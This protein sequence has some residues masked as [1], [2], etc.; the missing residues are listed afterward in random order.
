MSGKDAGRFFDL[1]RAVAKEK[2]GIHLAEH[3]NALIENRLIRLKSKVGF[4]GGLE[5]LM[6]AIQSGEYE[7][8]FISAFTTNQTSFFRE[9]TQLEHFKNEFLPS[10][11]KTKNS[12]SV[13]SAGCSSGEEP[14]SM[15]MC[16]LSS[17]YEE[18]A[19]KITAMDIDEEKLKSAKDGIYSQPHTNPFPSY[20]SQN[21]YFSA[22]DE[23]GVKKIKIKDDVK[24]MVV[25]EK[26]NLANNKEIL[27][28]S[29]YDAV[30]CRN[31][32]IYFDK[33]KQDEILKKLLQ[34]LKLGGYLYL[35]HSENPLS[36]IDR[37]QKKG[38]NIY[39]KKAAEEI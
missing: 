31:T 8:D 26:H 30:F 17:K 6:G 38:H 25:F 39:I 32:L 15:A 18:R 27:K 13:L 7:G 20:V 4:G 19:L 22:Y 3:K 21:V 5:E 29:F 12:L 1:V 14:Y 37:L 2:L 11:F 10:Q 24:S 36:H 16:F 9:P 28:N 33:K 34:S 23:R 35:G